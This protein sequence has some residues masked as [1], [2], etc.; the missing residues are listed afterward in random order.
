MRF[1]VWSTWAGAHLAAVDGDD[2]ASGVVELH[3]LGTLRR[4]AERHRDPPHRFFGLV[5]RILQHAAFVRD[6]QQIGV[7]RVG[8]TAFALLEVHGDAMRVGIGE[9]LLA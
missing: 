4:L 3:I 8:R 7:H 1:R 5:V 9:Q 6:V 2:V